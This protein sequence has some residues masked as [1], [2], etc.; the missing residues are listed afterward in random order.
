LATSAEW[1]VI[2]SI[3]VSFLLISSFAD[4]SPYL[5]DNFDQKPIERHPGAA[6]KFWLGCAGASLFAARQ[7]K[8]NNKVSHNKVLQDRGL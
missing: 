3:V 4:V 2:R 8:V 6:F 1:L 7:A 5:L